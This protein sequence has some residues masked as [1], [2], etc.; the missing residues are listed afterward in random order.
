VYDDELPPYSMG[1]FPP[2]TVPGCRAPHLWL[3]RGAS[4]YDDFG[5]GYTLLRIDRSIDVAPLQAAA[6][7][8]GMPLALI[9]LDDCARPD[10]YRHALLL[11]REDQHVAWRADALPANVGALVDMLRGA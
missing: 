9:D 5:P 11:C 8:V 7:T 3:H 1:E 10:G 6:R 4:L 2:S